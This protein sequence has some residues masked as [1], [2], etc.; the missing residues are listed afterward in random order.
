MMRTI[1]LILH[2]SLFASFWNSF[3]CHCQQIYWGC[4][5]KEEF[6]FFPVSNVTL[7][8]G[9]NIEEKSIFI[10]QQFVI[11]LL[12]ICH[13]MVMMTHVLSSLSASFHVLSF[14]AWGSNF[15]CWCKTLGCANSGSAGI[16]M[17]SGAL[18]NFDNDFC[19][20]IL[21]S[22][23]DIHASKWCPNSSSIGINMRSAALENLDT[24][25]CGSIF[26]SSMTS[27]RQDLFCNALCMHL[28]DHCLQCWQ[29]LGCYGLSS[30]LCFP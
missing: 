3:D 14:G 1:T 15:F 22:S 6:F 9:P 12:Q 24:V 29:L 21:I 23:N 19:G 2:N 30:R 16:N 25:F 7:C 17:H 18:E 5:C 26:I 8:L 28:L 27:M 11:V 20:S 10:S 4:S 13:L